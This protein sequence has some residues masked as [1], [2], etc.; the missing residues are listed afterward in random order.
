M[1]PTTHSLTNAQRSAVQATPSSV[2]YNGLMELTKTMTRAI[3]AAMRAQMTSLCGEKQLQASLKANAPHLNVQ[4]AAWVGTKAIL[5][6]QN[7][8]AK[9]IKSTSTPISVA[10][11]R[12]KKRV[13][14]FVWQAMTN[15]AT[16]HSLLTTKRTAKPAD[17]S[18]KTTLMEI[19]S[20]KR[21]SKRV[22]I[23]VCAD[24]AARR[25]EARAICHG[26]W[27][28]RTKRTPNQWPVASFRV[29]DF[30]LN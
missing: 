10:K 8:A 20:T 14:T 25:M 5:M 11:R 3:Q 19:G 28:K 18:L 26:L 30:W 15:S 4:N 7:T 17:Q 29:S 9:T 27:V 16:C 1:L 21:K 24:T 23:M 12:W 2:G 6:P 22:W 13:W